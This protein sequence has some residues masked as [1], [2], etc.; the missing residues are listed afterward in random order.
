MFDIHFHIQKSKLNNRTAYNFTMHN[1]APVELFCYSRY[2]PKCLLL[3]FFFALLLVQENLQPCVEQD[4][5]KGHIVNIGNLRSFFS[6]SFFSALLLGAKNES[7]F[8]CFQ[9][10][11]LV[12]LTLFAIFFSFE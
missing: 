6:F 2:V 9:L 3:L 8:S 7:I 12:M 1:F 11:T 10:P 5:N 4:L